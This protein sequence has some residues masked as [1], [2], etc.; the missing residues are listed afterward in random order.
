MSY[1]TWAIDVNSDL[2]WEDHLVRE[3]Q[4]VVFRLSGLHRED[5]LRAVRGGLVAAGGGLH[6]LPEA[7]DL[8]GHPVH[9]FFNQDALRGLAHLL[10]GQAVR[11]GED[12]V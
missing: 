3:G 11:D 10:E 4:R 5:Q 8:H 1:F 7:E 6:G 12:G 2:G 9:H